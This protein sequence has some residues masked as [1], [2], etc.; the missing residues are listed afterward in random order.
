MSQKCSGL[1]LAKSCGKGWVTGGI[2]GATAGASFGG[3]MGGTT[4]AIVGGLN[5]SL[6]G[7]VHGCVT[8]TTKSWLN[9]CK[10]RME[11]TV[12]DIPSAPSH[13]YHES[14]YRFPR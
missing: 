7:G 13:P 14:H 8:S 2:A 6:I 1:Y 3:L 9:S 12:F 11:I 5:G 4:G 10:P